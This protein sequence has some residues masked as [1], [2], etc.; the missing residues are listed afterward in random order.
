MHD[1]RLMY[2]KM[3]KKATEIKKKI[4]LIHKLSASTSRLSK[5]LDPRIENTDGDMTNN[6]KDGIEKVIARAY[7]DESNNHLRMKIILGKRASD[8][9]LDCGVSSPKKRRQDIR[10][11]GTYLQ[12]LHKF[13]EN[14][15]FEY[16]HI[17]DAVNGIFKTRNGRNSTI[18]QILRNREKVT[19]DL[20]ALRNNH[21]DTI[22]PLKNYSIGP[23]S[24]YRGTTNAVRTEH[25][26]PKTCSPRTEIT[27][28]LSQVEIQK[29]S[30]DEDVEVIPPVPAAIPIEHLLFHKKTK[31]QMPETEIEPKRRIILIDLTD[32]FDVKRETDTDKDQEPEQIKMRERTYKY[33]RKFNNP[34]AKHIVI[35]S[36][37]CANGWTNPFPL[38]ASSAEFEPAI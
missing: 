6:W 37:G 29:T 15:I 13:S 5:K 9:K 8:S 33:S 3:R 31:S 2:K 35:G 11:L 7:L 20:D 32:D 1:G 10:N 24:C 16:D 4:R 19:K 17:M 26:I 25:M 34:Y 30:Q 21:V 36:A 23:Q 14:P 27:N 22:G 18:V 38:F 12:F 28:E